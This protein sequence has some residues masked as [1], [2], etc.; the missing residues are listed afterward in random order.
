MAQVTDYLKDSADYIDDSSLAVIEGLTD[1]QF[2]AL[3]KAT[4]ELSPGS[5]DPGIDNS[6]VRTAETLEDFYNAQKQH[7]AE[8]GARE[9]LDVNG[10]SAVKFERVQMRKGQPRRDFLVIDFGDFR[11]ALQ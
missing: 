9:V 8:C 7:W 2:A 4:D 5:S 1:Q 11:A 10:F 3:V 6:V